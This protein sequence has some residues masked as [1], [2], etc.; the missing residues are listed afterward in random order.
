MGL[1]DL[2]AAGQGHVRQHLGGAQVLHDGEEAVV[3][4]V[5]LQQELF[6]IVGIHR[7][8]CSRCPWNCF[9]QHFFERLKKKM[10]TTQM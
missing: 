3:V 9:F 7:Y 4:V 8:G 5:P 2:P 6:L 10:R 1:E